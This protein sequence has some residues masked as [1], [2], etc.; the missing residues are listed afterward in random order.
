MFWGAHLKTGQSHKLFSE[1]PEESN[2][3][4]ISTA[5]LAPGSDGNL[6]S[7]NLTN[8]TLRIRKD[9]HPS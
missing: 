9:I 6:Y 4:Y 7:K 3:L 5:A 1:K 2:V 8:H